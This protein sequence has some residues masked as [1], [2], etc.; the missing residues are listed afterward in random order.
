[1]CFL[2]PSFSSLPPFLP[3]LISSLLLLC[4]LCM[5]YCWW[6]L[7][8]SFVLDRVS[9]CSPDWPRTPYAN[10][11]GL[12]LT[13]LF[14]LP[15]INTNQS[16]ILLYRDNLETFIFIYNL[17]VQVEHTRAYLFY[18]IFAKTI[19]KILLK[20]FYIYLVCV[21]VVWM[22]WMLPRSYFGTQSLTVMVLRTGISFE[23]VSKPLT[24]WMRF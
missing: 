12:E 19:L 6:C 1:M 24:S 8:P 5:F 18:G 21:C 3:S 20:I 15:T 17:C 13:E 10:Q 16:I 4:S 14:L 2:F 22:L 9:R 11:S 23:I 7:L